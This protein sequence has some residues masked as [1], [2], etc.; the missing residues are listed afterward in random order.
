MGKPTEQAAG[1]IIKKVSVDWTIEVDAWNCPNKNF[2]WCKTKKCACGWDICPLKV[3]GTF[4][5]EDH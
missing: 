3:L 4:K 2:Q 1:F 5:K